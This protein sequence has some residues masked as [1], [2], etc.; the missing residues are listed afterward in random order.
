MT[1][2]SVTFEDVRR[3]GERT[4]V[5]DLVLFVVISQCGLQ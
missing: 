2:T 3:I 5:S 4:D 1:L